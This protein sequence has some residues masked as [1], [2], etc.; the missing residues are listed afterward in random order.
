MNDPANGM[1]DGR[2]EPIGAL[3]SFEDMAEFER[4]DASLVCRFAR[5]V[6]ALSTSRRHGGAND[7]VRA[8][9]N[10]QIC[11]T[12]ECPTC[13]VCLE[14]LNAHLD[15]HAAALGC[16]PEHA[17]TML[18]SADMNNAGW[19]EAA[20]ED[21]RVLAVVT[22]GVC[23]NAVRAGDAATHYETAEG[24]KPVAASPNPGTIN[25]MLL[26]NRRL[27]PD[28]LVK[29]CIMATEA[30]AATLQAL[31][32][33]SMYGRGIATGT[34]TDQCVI[35]CP[36]DSPFV[37]SEAQGHVKLGEMIAY[38]V[39][40]ALRATLARETGLT[41]ATRRSVRAMLMR[42]G[43]DVDAGERDGA[44][45]AV[46]AAMALAALFDQT[47]WG[48]LPPDELSRIAAPQVALLAAAL[49]DKPCASAQAETALR[50]ADLPR[51]PQLF[52]K[53]VACALAL[54]R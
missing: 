12:G 45:E 40:E 32:V 33:R 21:V 36:Q 17:L 46:A 41:P 51:A 43:G 16:E 19:C 44:P 9:I 48:V 1:A 37:L 28:A 22:G 8:A 14:D 20:H 26:I 54:A 38:A 25:L 10:Y 29:A 50:A 15:A 5:P 24:W 2:H 4:S 49:S 11:R 18:T 30:K 52:E 23:V 6:H 31:S 39:S 42:F 3:R 35:A 34:G 7:R 13:R 47:D 53:I 27:T